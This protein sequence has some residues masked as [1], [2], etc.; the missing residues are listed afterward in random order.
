MQYSRFLSNIFD[1]TQCSQ[2]S[3]SK[4]DA[5]TFIYLDAEFKNETSSKIEEL[6]KNRIGI[7]DRSNS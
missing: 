5:N 4:K 3:Q 2:K 7:L 1:I 6:V